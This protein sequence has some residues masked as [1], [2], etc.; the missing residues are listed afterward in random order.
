MRVI[1]YLI[2]SILLNLSSNA[3]VHSIVHRLTPVLLFISYWNCKMMLLSCS[4]MVLLLAIKAFVVLICILI[5]IGFFISVD[6]VLVH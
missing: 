2:Q 5:V 1:V 4:K 6:I 3:V